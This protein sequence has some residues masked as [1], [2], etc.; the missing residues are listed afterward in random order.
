MKR[1]IL[2]GHLKIMSGLNLKNL[3]LPVCECLFIDDDKLIVDN[4][5]EGR[6]IVNIPSTGV[7]TLVDFT[8]LKNIVSKSKAENITFEA[9][10]TTELI[11]MLDNDKFTFETM[12]YD[13]FPK[14][15]EPFAS[16]T[17]QIELRTNKK[18]Q[19]TEESIYGFPENAI[20]HFSIATGF[21]SKDELRPQMECV[22]LD[23]N[24]TATNAHILYTVPINLNILHPKEWPAIE[25]LLLIS[26]S[27]QRLAIL[28]GKPFDIK[29]RSIIEKTK[30]KVIVKETSLSLHWNHTYTFYPPDNILRFPNW[31]NVFPNHKDEEVYLRMTIS[32]EKLK[33]SFSMA[34][35]VTGSVKKI[36]FSAD[37]QEQTFKV[38]A[39][40]LDFNTSYCK[41][42]PA[43]L[44]DCKSD[45]PYLFALD[46]KFL[47]EILKQIKEP[48]LSM[49]VQI[50]DTDKR[51]I[52]IDDKFLIMPIQLTIKK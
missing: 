43:V 14:Q 21:Q 18:L 1:K 22:Y 31:K 15:R 24:L 25:E 40:D 44:H 39:E 32:T 19:V 51:A 17:T 36:Y 42:F 50:K 38:Y 13:D 26:K 46:G 3:M 8:K 7:K 45:K 37:C 2:E 48:S 6:F 52:I 47:G 23:N 34:M 27:A 20:K 41:T 35:E 9:P 16:E 11:V 10:S 49:F 12:N 4:F 30:D 29:A 28:I 5:Q 33:E